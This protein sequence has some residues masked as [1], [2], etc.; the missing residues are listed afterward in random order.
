MSIEIHDAMGRVVYNLDHTF[1]SMDNVIHLPVDQ[2][3]PRSY[4]IKLLAQ[5]DDVEMTLSFE[6]II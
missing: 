1:S 6:I 2:L 5:D 3:T 4:Y